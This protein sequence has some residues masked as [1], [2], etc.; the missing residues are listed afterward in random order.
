MC[1]TKK[2]AKRAAA[3]SLTIANIIISNVKVDIV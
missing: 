1:Q 2:A 3:F